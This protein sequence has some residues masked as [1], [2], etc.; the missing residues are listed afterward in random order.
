M[1]TNPTQIHLS[2]PG[3]PASSLCV[4]WQ[5]PEAWAAWDLEHQS[6]D[7][8]DFRPV[9]AE[10]FPSPGRGF[11]QRAHIEGLSA[12]T[13]VAFRFVNRGD[14]EQRT[15]VYRARTAPSGPRTGF[16]FIF[17]ADTGLIGRPDG[18]TTGT[19][20]I[21]RRIPERDPLFLLGGG[22]YAYA[23]KDGRFDC[24]GDAVDEWFRQAEPMLSRFPL[25]AQ[26][27]NHEILLKERY[28]DWETR[29][30][31]PPGFD[32]ERSYAFDVAAVHFA[33]L[34]MPDWTRVDQRHVDWLDDDLRRAREAGARRLIVF[35]HESIY[36][37]G[38]SHP[39][40]RQ[41]RDPLA[42]IFERHRVDLV[43]NAHDQNYERTYPLTHRKGA[44]GLEPVVMDEGLRY[45]PNW[46]GVVY[47]KISPAG[48]MSEKGNCF[49]K[50]TVPQQEFIA[51]RDDTAHHYAEVSV[52]EDSAVAVCVIRYEPENDR[53]SVE[54]EFQLGGTRNA[55]T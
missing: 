21:Y 20:A 10:L 14:P 13:A 36:G 2:W 17:F 27:G 5:V 31:H 28:E 22:D 9:R 11:L 15:A 12:D 52:T 37:H 55:G 19:E 47:A 35:Q 51:V 42:P 4:T 33:A 3:D 16:S 40:F 24:I 6:D 54:D 26:Y 18:N 53:F 32:S 25:Y 23:N 43:L 38:K 30:A 1:T 8:G 46:K 34:F 45:Y 50:F 7:S 39:S 29:F 41:V 44:D 48:K 49:S